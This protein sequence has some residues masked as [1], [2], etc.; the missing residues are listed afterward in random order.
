MLGYETIWKQLIG[1]NIKFYSIIEE[2]LLS[3]KNIEKRTVRSNIDLDWDN[4]FSDES[5]FWAQS[6]VHYA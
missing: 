5:S 6:S 1:N 2:T 3:Q 4:V